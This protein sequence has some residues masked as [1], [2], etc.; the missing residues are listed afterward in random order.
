MPVRDKYLSGDILPIILMHACVTDFPWLSL[1]D[2]FPDRRRFERWANKQPSAILLSI[3]QQELR[4]HKPMGPAGMWARA[5]YNFSRWQRPHRLDEIFVEA[6]Y[7][8]W[9]KTA[10]P[11]ISYISVI[12]SGPIGCYAVYLG[13]RIQYLIANPPNVW[14]D[15]FAKRTLSFGNAALERY[16]GGTT[17]NSLEN[18]LCIFSTANRRGSGGAPRARKSAST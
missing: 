14:W 18:S 1:S 15:D 10:L 3:Q 16:S 9:G 17:P 12:S 13:T 6:M 11:K 7:P 4:E 8:L 5:E 2:N